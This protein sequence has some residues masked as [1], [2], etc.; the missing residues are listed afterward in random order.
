MMIEP[1]LDMIVCT[2][3]TMPNERFRQGPTLHVEQGQRRQGGAF[4]WHVRHLNSRLEPVDFGTVLAHRLQREPLLCLAAR[5]AWSLWND[6][7]PFEELED[8]VGLVVEVT[9]GDDNVATIYVELDEASGRYTGSAA[10]C[11]ELSLATFDSRGRRDAGHW[12]RSVL[13]EVA[14]GDVKPLPP[15]SRGATLRTLPACWKEG[16]ESAKDSVLIYFL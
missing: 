4:D 9:Y 6:D 3:L 15:V 5:A 12:V 2:Q 7:T 10:P 14:F 11:F 1:G 16:A 8:Y 13:N